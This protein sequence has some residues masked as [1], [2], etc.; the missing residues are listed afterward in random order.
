MRAGLERVLANPRYA[1][2]RVY[3]VRESGV[4]LK[5]ATRLTPQDLSVFVGTVINL[6]K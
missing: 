3:H 5:G 1:Q 2:R 6:P 4:P